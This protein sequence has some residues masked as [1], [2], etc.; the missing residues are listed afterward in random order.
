MQR[1]VW[2]LPFTHRIFFS[3]KF[4]QQGNT[5][6]GFLTKNRS[7]TILDFFLRKKICV[8]SGKGYI[9]IYFDKAA[10]KSHKLG[11]FSFTKIRGS[12]ITQSLILKGR[13]KRKQKD[14]KGKKVK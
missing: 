6:D 9:S 11:E 14:N 3:N 1:V 7:S 4:S 13:F 10:F 8:Y 5:V 2:K 12:A